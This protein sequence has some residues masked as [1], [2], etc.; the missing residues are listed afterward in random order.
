MSPAALRVTLDEGH[1]RAFEFEGGVG[2][3]GRYDIL[4]V[5]GVCWLRLLCNDIHR[6]ER[7]EPVIGVLN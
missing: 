6:G 7:V 2:N 3:V 4:R 1:G 5:C